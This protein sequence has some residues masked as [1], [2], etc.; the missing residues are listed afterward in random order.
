MSFNVF[1]ILEMFKKSFGKFWLLILIVILAF[2]LR[3]Y[4]LGDY[5]VGLTWDEPA[6]GYNAYSILKTG[7]DEYGK[8]FP[9]TFKSFGDY[10]PGL[11]VYYLIP[12]VWIFGL[13]EF[14]IRFPSALAGVGTI[15]AVFFLVKIIF[16][17]RKEVFSLALLSSLL[18][19][20]SPWNIH[21][22]RGA[23]EANFALFTIV[24]GVIFL[25]KFSFF[26]A[27]IFFAFSFYVY[28]GAKVFLVVF[29]GGSLLFLFKDLRRLPQEKKRIGLILLFLLLIPLFTSFKGSANRAKVMSIFSYK[30]PEEE[31]NKTFSQ[32]EGNRNLNF[33]LYHSEILETGRGILNRY[34][35]HFSGRF[36]F[37]EGD[38]GS[39]RHSVPYMGMMYFA[40]IPFLILGIGYFLA[41]KKTSSENL[42]IW[43]LL[44][45]PVP[46]A[47]TRDAVH[48]IRSYWMVIP[49]VI[50]TSLGIWR[51]FSL[52][53]T[54][55]PKFFFPSLFFVFSVYI[56]CF[57]L[58]LDLYY[59]H[60]PKK[61][62]FGWNYG[63]KE[64]AKIIE[65][66]KSKYSKIIMT[67]KYGQPYIFYLFYNQ[68]PPEKYQKQAHL[69]E[70]PWGDVGI[71][72]RIDN[73]EFRNVYWPDDRNCQNCLF[74]DDELGL[75]EKDI[76]QTPGARILKEIKFL[77]GRIAYRIVETK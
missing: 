39:P 53:R 60:F 7:R 51:F 62:S 75:P 70:N 28:H 22:S 6:L 29:L 21:F 32:E 66:G 24:L 71:V 55:W 25:L 48:G 1:K 65:E 34:L 3:V 59:I 23:W 50:F 40:E 76:L 5:P 30:R 26:P 49:L 18:L 8:F 41:T 13:N 74:I 31:I 4:K 17:K 16:E 56:F 64:V 20:I 19:A 46:A 67:Q 43:W 52:V 33:L 68:Y 73:I 12:S 10:K 61:N 15:V 9:I 35:N 77:D 63:A 36:L 11:F 27:F 47:I 38:W 2:A 54:C 42:L 14:A 69:K 57:I 44:M 45:G 72:E 58:Y 37:F